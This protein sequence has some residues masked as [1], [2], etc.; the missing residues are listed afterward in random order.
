MCRS[1]EFT[2]DSHNN[3]GLLYVGLAYPYLQPVFRRAASDD[4][5]EYRRQTTRVHTSHT[6][7]RHNTFNAR[8][9][10]QHAAA[11]DPGHSMLTR[12]SAGNSG[13]QQV[14]VGQQPGSTPPA[15]SLYHSS[16]LAAAGGNENAQNYHSDAGTAATQAA[17]TSMLGQPTAAWWAT[18]ERPSAAIDRIVGSLASGS[19]HSS[20]RAASPSPI[21]SVKLSSYADELP[22]FGGRGIGA[23][24][25]EA[26]ASAPVKKSAYLLG[27]NVTQDVSLLGV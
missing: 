17:G 4:L 13:L 27:K 20:S 7:N 21:P 14:I 1:I 5:S 19:V 8:N 15:G 2:V 22:D 16:A 18:A 26:P 6:L 9:S 25:R 23:I 12:Q 11:V 3:G 24:Y 10:A